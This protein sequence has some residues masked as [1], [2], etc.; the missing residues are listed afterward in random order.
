LNEIAVGDYCATFTPPRR[1]RLTGHLSKNL[2]KM[3]LIGQAALY[4]DIA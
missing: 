4:C 1:W 3:S 2:T